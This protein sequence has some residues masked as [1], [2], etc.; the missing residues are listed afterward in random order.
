MVRLESNLNPVVLRNS[1]II[2]TII[3][4]SEPNVEAR[5]PLCMFCFDAANFP[6]LNRSLNGLKNC[7]SR[8]V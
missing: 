2:V 7:R 6:V 3:F 1:I 5:A 8:Y 4:I